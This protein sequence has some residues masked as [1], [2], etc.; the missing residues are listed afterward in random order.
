M[1]PVTLEVMNQETGDVA[2]RIKGEPASVHEVFR[3]MQSEAAWT[4]AARKMGV[5]VRIPEGE[6]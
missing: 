5:D 2:I 1:K 4:E 3:L 6:Q